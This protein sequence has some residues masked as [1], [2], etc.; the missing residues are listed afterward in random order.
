MNSQKLKSMVIAAML[1]RDQYIIT[2]VF[3]IRIVL[4]LVLFTL[5]ACSHF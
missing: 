5:A 2:D 3:T 4:E 1:E